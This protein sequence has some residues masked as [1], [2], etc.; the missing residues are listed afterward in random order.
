M[1]PLVGSMGS[2]WVGEARKVSIRIATGVFEVKVTALDAVEAKCAAIG[3]TEGDAFINLTKAAENELH[4]GF[5]VD[6][7][8]ATCEIL[9]T[10]AVVKA[11]VGDG[12]NTSNCEVTL[13]FAVGACDGV[14][15]ASDLLTRL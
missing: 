7:P 4:E 12:L 11:A 15:I 3:F 9:P 13:G 8:V 6:V 5:G 14:Y 1:V 2:L 10:T